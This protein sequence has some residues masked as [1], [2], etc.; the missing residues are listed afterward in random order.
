MA[1]SLPPDELARR[2]R[3]VGYGFLGALLLW[4]LAEGYALGAGTGNTLSAIVRDQVRHPIGR[5]LV[6]PLWAWLTWHWYLAPVI[7][8][9]W[10][11][12]VAVGVGLLVALV[13]TWGQ[14]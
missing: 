14:G 4:A 5:F 2:R 9:T 7:R 1:T 10:R 3:V 8:P 11:D 12:L 13:V 6:Y